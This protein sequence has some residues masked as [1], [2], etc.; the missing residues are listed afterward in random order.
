MKLE[1]CIAC[2]K[3][4]DNEFV[5]ALGFNYHPICFVQNVTC[6]LCGK[7][8]QFPKMEFKIFNEQAYHPICF[9][10]VTGLEKEQTFQ[11]SM[12]KGTIFFK[13]K[14]PNKI[15]T[16]NESFMYEFTIDNSTQFMINYIECGL[17]CEETRYARGFNG[18]M[19]GSTTQS[20]LAKKKVV[21][22]GGAMKNGVMNKS[23]MFSIG[24]VRPSHHNDIMFYRGYKF[25][26]SLKVSGTLTNSKDI[27][28]PIYINE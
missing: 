8:F 6:K 2:N 7:P 12:Q 27:V 25:V 13:V 3:H 20:K 17:V 11:P 21:F 22:D 4:I 10:G 9:E 28:Y 1:T 23:E 14:M 15:F 18:E 5:S 24:M 19:K 26:I 16:V